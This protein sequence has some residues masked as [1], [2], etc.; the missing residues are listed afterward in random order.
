VSSR[1]R[2]CRD[3]RSLPRSHHGRAEGAIKV[4]SPL[5][6]LFETIGEQTRPIS[7]SIWLFTN[8]KS[9]DTLLETLIVVFLGMPY[10]SLVPVK[11]LI[12]SKFAVDDPDAECHGLHGDNSDS[13]P[14]PLTY[15]GLSPILFRDSRNNQKNAGRAENH[16]LCVRGPIPFPICWRL[17]RAPRWFGI[18]GGL[19]RLSAV[20]VFG[21]R[22]RRRE[23]VPCYEECMVGVV[24]SQ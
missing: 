8:I 7:L 1:L 13:C 9:G 11:S 14:A 16:N 17:L 22:M 5:G 6:F 24:S 12:L 10:D 4:L 23:R 18:A 21:R 3:W 19:A 15:S 20:P 2:S